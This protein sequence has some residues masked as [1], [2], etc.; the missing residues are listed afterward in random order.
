[1]N[2]YL[3]VSS[4]PEIK[5]NFTIALWVKPADF[6]Q[7]MAVM[8]T[9]GGPTDCPFSIKVPKGGGIRFSLNDGVKCLVKSG[10]SFLGYYPDRWYHLA[11]VVTPSDVTYYLNGELYYRFTFA[12]ATP[13]LVYRYL[14]L[15]NDGNDPDPWKGALDDFRLYNRALKSDEIAALLGTSALKLLMSSPR[16]SR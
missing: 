8:G 9:P 11:F 1:M 5:E 15:G 12:A 16:A 13:T 7:D 2:D 3:T 6:N 14:S 4:L 10:A